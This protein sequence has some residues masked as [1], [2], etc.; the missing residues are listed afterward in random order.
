MPPLII[1]QVRHTCPGAARM[2]AQ[3]WSTFLVT[4]GLSSMIAGRL[5]KSENIKSIR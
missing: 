4:I 2:A 1:K 5:M 3:A